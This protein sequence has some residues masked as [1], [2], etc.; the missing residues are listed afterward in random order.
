MHTLGKMAL[1]YAKTRFGG[2][3]GEMHVYNETGEAVLEK[4]IM[5]S[6]RPG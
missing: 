4:F 2:A 1:D 3:S 6:G 5:D